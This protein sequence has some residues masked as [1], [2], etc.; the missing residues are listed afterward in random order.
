MFFHRFGW[1]IYFGLK[2]ILRQQQQ[3]KNEKGQNKFP[4][5]KKHFHCRRRCFFFFLIA[6]FHLSKNDRNVMITTTTINTHKLIRCI[7][8][9]SFVYV[10]YG[11]KTMVYVSALRLQWMNEPI[12]WHKKQKGMEWMTDLDRNLHLKDRSIYYNINVRFVCFADKHRMPV[13]WYGIF[14]LNIRVYVILS[15]TYF[16]INR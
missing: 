3:Q 11:V 2:Q 9:C 10:F 8:R 16:C 5:H 15:G 1:R 13:L 12:K 6:L 7:L 14:V 4:L